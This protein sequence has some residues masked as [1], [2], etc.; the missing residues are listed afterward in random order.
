M[1][2][3]EAETQRLIKQGQHL[4]RVMFH[5]LEDAGL[6][7]GM[8]VLDLG[9]GAGDVALAAAAIVG[10]DGSVEGIDQHENVLKTARQ[11]AADVGFNNVHFSVA[12]IN[13]FQPAGQ[14]DAIIGRRVLTYLN[15]PG[16]TLKDLAPYVK[17][18]GIFAFDEFDAALD[19]VTVPSSPSIS[20]V[21]GWLKDVRIK[22]GE[23]MYLGLHLRKLFLDAGF[24]DPYMQAYATVFTPERPT[25]AVTSLRSM[26]STVLE[27]GVVTREELD[28]DRLEADVAEECRRLDSVGAFYGSIQAWARKP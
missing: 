16:Q 19:A 14:F 6:A 8:R 15:D 28:F 21:W 2:N 11:R 24:V 23:H 17:N 5:F 26:E 27:S 12:D 3:S 18:G 9:S 4:D 13:R 22:A 20:R 1:G 10:P 25:T 7:P